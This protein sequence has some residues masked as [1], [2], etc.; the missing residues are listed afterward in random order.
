MDFVRLG[1]RYTANYIPDKLIEGY[2][3]LIWTERFSQLGEF[4]LK[5]YDVDGLGALLPEDTLVSHLETREV[6]QVETHEIEMEGEGVDAVPVITIRGRSASSILEHRWVESTYQKK[7]RMRRSYSSTSAAAVLL[8]NAVDNASGKDLTRGDTNA[9]TPELNDYGWTTLDVIPNVA[10]TEAVPS[11]GPLRWWQ[12]EE[13]IL[14]PQL[15]KILERDDLGLRCLRPVSPNPATVITVYADL[16]RRGTIVRTANPNVTQL[17]FDIYAGVD[18]TG[19]VKFSQLQG[20]LDKPTYL[21][22]SREVKSLAEIKSGEVQVSDVY[23]SNSHAALTGWRRRTLEFDAGTP[24]LPPAPEKPEELKKNATKAERDARADAMDKWIDDMAKWR[25]KRDAIVADFR[26]EAT[27]AAKQELKAKRRVNM[28]SGDVSLSSPYIYKTN[29]DLGDIVMLNGDYGKSAVMR[30]S[31]YVR[32]EDA[33]GDRGFP[34]LVE[35]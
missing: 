15:M 33:N 1:E 31:E 24:E 17:Q 18:R 9:E 27:E 34:G 10:V 16:A 4:E 23:L 14:Y 35:P 8:V 22:S 5:S 20:H 26:A 3:S 29:Y 11:E 25:N 2:N 21:T 6:M 30:V 12:L 32:T 13:G 19:T 28:F 7:R